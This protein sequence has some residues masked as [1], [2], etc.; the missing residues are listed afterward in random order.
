MFQ[1]FYQSLQL[2]LKRSLCRSTVVLKHASLSAT[3]TLALR[4]LIAASFS[5]KLTTIFLIHILSVPALV[6]HI[7]TLAPEVHAQFFSSSY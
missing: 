4:P 5:D 6:F 2:L 7:Q 1:G 3:V